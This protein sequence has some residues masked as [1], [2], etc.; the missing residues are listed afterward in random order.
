MQIESRHKRKVS[1]QIRFV[2]RI[3]YCL[4]DVGQAFEI[5]DC[6]PGVCLTAA[7]GHRQIRVERVNA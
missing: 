6:G 7:R 2:Q 4:A 5:E 3:R 1:E